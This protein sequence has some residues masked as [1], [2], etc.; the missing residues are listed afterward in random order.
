MLCVILDSFFRA[1]KSVGYNDRVAG[2][3][4]NYEMSMLIIALTATESQKLMEESWDEGVNDGCTS[5]IGRI[6]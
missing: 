2:K 4:E 1:P 6:L 3:D 5:G